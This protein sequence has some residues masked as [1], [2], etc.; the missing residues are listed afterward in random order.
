MEP[1]YQNLG[2]LILMLL[3]LG[4]SAFFSIAETAFFNLSKRQISILKKSDHKL[5]RLTAN[6]LMDPNKL[7]GTV[8]FGNTI[9]N[10]LFYAVSSTITAQLRNQLGV[11]AIAIMAI[12]TFFAVV[13]FGEILPKSIAFAN[14]RPISI[15][16]SLPLF[17]LV[18]IL[19]PVLKFFSFFI[20]DPTVR[21]LI[22]QPKKTSTIKPDDFKLLIDSS[23]KKGFITSDENKLFSEVIELGFL[24]VRH[25]MKPRVDMTLCSIKDS[26]QNVRQ[27]MLKKNL[28]KIAIYDHEV[29]NIVGLIHLRD[30]LLSRDKTIDKL[31]KPVKFIPEQKT[32]ESL[33]EFFK[34]TAI[35]TAIVVDE[36]GGLAG[37]IR[38]EDIAEELI[39]EI[40]SSSRQ[41]IEQIS[42][43]MYRLS[44]N[45]SI[46]D[47]ADNFNIESID[48]RVSTI[49]GLVTAL[50]GKIPQESDSVDMKNL[51]FTVESVKKHR[52]QTLILTF[53]SLENDR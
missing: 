3:L 36:Y 13:L 44:G 40:E 6:L 46:H 35:D 19:S 39:G 11:T 27:L 16:L 20:V 12:A 18:K 45:L 10:I 7:L 34:K 48:E 43:F 52:I 2:H 23:R 50:L 9:V 25:V 31:I 29:D 38:L 37:S 32:I 49:G 4:G 22:G 14:P 28:S 17:F 1:F 26:N 15:T 8:L 30:L 47:W 42:P 5:Q 21:L 51:N 41:K 33:L 24:K 53:K